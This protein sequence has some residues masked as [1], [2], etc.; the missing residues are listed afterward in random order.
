MIRK[1]VKI[2]EGKCNGCG[3][4]IDACHEG[5][6]QL[7]NGK[8]RLVT[9]AYCDGLGDCLPECPQDAISIIEREAAAFDEEAVK[10]HLEVQ[11]TLACG[12]PGSS[13][14][15]L[16]KLKDSPNISGTKA[17]STPGELTQA[18]SQ[19]SQWPCQIKLV[20]VNAPFLDNS[21]LLIA[22]DC[23]AYAYADF[24]RDFMKD[25]ITLV[26]CPKLDNV[27]YAEKLTEMFRLHEINSITVVR[28]TVPCCGSLA[29]RVRQAVRDSGRDIPVNVV[30][31]D[32]A[33]CIVA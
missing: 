28:M 19:L 30:T 25:R 7:I 9:D 17:E 23:S 1:I 8:A 24:H 27:D 32:T 2:N 26:G 13:V 11:E 5:A 29:N 4:C 31:I 3:L 14:T 18:E 6:L 22:A 20:P 21:D 15:V 12:C 33:G 16:K 10:K